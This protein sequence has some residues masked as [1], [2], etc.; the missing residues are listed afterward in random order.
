MTG[1]TRARVL[2]T[3]D[4][5]DTKS[6][7]ALRALEIFLSMLEMNHLRGIFFITGEMANRL[8]V[9]T[10]N[11]KRLRTHE[12][13]YH[14]SVHSERP[15]LIERVDLQDFHKAIQKSMQIEKDARALPNLRRLFSKDLTKFRAPR[16]CWNPAHMVAL[17]RLGIKS[18]FSADFSEK[19]VQCNGLIFYPS[20]IW[21]D[22]ILRPGTWARFLAKI[23]RGG[24]IVV[25]LHPS[26][27]LYSGAW[28]WESLEPEIGI[29]HRQRPNSTLGVAAR[30]VAYQMFF[31][32]IEGCTRI[33]L[34]ETRTNLPANETE[35]LDPSNLQLSRVYHAAVYPSLKFINYLPKYW[36]SQLEAFMGTSSSTD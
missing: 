26:K 1:S 19:I 16:M 35:S 13:G 17:R 15:T 36:F 9:S 28:D 14:T 32:L 27:I 18:D 8:K 4:V 31:G 20:P 7:D 30:I 12:I 2:L 23:A 29:L 5:E 25:A 11:V 21:V 6:P 10:S 33:G 34:I 24:V 22:T 3:F